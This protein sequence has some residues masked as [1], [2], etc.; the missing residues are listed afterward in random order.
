MT[1]LASY[2]VV[3]PTTDNDGNPL[4]DGI[5]CNV[6]FGVDVTSLTWTGP[7]MSAPPTSVTTGQVFNFSYSTSTNSWWPS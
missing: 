5:S 3:M 2:T 6:T 1:T 7:F 4:Q